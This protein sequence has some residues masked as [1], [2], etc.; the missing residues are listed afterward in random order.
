MITSRRDDSKVNAEKMI[1]LSL[2]DM[3]MVNVL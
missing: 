2:I 3:L 1:T